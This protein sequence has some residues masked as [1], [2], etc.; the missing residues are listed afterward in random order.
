MPLS[1]PW[2]VCEVRHGDCRNTLDGTRVVWRVHA[3][4]QAAPSLSLANDRR[5]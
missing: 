3:S 4:I 2:S 5:R 1:L